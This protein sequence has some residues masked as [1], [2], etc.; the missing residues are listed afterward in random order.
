MTLSYLTVK[1]TFW[2]ILFL[3]IIFP[4]C[5]ELSRYLFNATSEQITRLTIDIC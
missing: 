2:G 3:P 1:L 4:L 5:F